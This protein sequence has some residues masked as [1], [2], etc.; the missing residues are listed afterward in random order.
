MYRYIYI[1]IIENDKETNI[2]GWRSYEQEKELS[3]GED[4]IKNKMNK[5]I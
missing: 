2:D 5:N 3:K 1:Y 4:I